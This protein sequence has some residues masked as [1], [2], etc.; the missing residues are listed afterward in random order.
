M[1]I[2]D[3]F[4]EGKIRIYVSDELIEEYFDVLSRP[5]FQRFPDFAKKAEL[6]LTEITMKSVKYTPEIKLDIISDQD[7]NM[8]LE[9]AYES[10]ADFIITGNTNDFTISEYL[11][12]K[13]VTP[14]EFWELTINNLSLNKG[15]H[16]F[17]D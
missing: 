15:N 16:H 9:L 14:R 4:L 3:L 12:T 7:D 6:I 5:K 2:F 10:K 13:I 1:I 11:H 17:F 8:I